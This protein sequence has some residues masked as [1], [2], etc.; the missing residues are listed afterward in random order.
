[1][2]ARALA[3]R[4]AIYRIARAAQ[5]RWKPE[6]DDVAVLNDEVR[7]AR[8]HERLAGAPPLAWAWDDDDALD[9]VLW[10]VACDAAALF[11]DEGALGRI[12]Q[13][14]GPECGWLFQDT[15]RA[16]RRKWCDMADCGNVAKVQ[17]F[18][19]RQG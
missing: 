4:E 18:R 15:S 11:T 12:G 6:V 7:I 8:S 14:P 17:R 5:E 19:Q 16:G 2:H 1:M 10:P 13:C 3:L 9:R